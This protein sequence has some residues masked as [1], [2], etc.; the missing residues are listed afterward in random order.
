M[1]RTGIKKLE[2]KRLTVKQ[3]TNVGGAG[4]YV[5]VSRDAG[6]SNSCSTCDEGNSACWAYVPDP[7]EGCASDGCGGS[8][9]GGGNMDMLNLMC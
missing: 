8:G 3:L 1:K 2:L 9:C 5:L 6:C 4:H 7:S